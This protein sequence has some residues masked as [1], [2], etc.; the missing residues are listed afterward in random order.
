MQAGLDL[1]GAQSGQVIQ[2]PGRTVNPYVAH[3][4]NHVIRNFVVATLA[5]A[6]WRRSAAATGRWHLIEVGQTTTTKGP[7]D[8]FA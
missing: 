5:R 3:C 1:R 6:P 8:A 4:G 2:L 7:L